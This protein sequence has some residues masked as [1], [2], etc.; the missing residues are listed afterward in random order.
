MGDEDTYF[1][2][3]TDGSGNDVVHLWIDGVEVARFKPNGD[4]DLA[5]VVNETAF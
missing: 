4:L 5:G 2:C 1:Q 3:I